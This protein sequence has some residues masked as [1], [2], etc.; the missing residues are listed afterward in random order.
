M[1]LHIFGIG[2]NGLPSL[3]AEAAEALATCRTLIGGNR[4]LK[5][6]P[7]GPK[8]MP[9][10]NPFHIPV[11]AIDNVPHPVGVLVSGDPSWYSVTKELLNLYECQIWQE[12]HPLL[13]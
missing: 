4:H 5:M 10:P 6:V 13:L 7:K 8:K 11:K 12:T 2:A 9:W 3:S 1:K